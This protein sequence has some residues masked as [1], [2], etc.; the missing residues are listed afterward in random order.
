VVWVALVV[1]GLRGYSHELFRGVRNA[2]ARER[3]E[4]LSPG[5]LRAATAAGG[6]EWLDAWRASLVGCNHGVDAVTNS[7]IDFG[8]AIDL[9][10]TM[11]AAACAGWL[12]ARVGRRAVVF[13]GVL[14]RCARCPAGE[15]R[16]WPRLYG[17]AVWKGRRRSLFGDAAT[18]RHRP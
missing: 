10:S 6:V 14:I 11:V 12:T 18:G 15:G 9:V 5:S 13:A 8:T 16:G 3:A 1:E 4:E 2:L 17:C 7:Q